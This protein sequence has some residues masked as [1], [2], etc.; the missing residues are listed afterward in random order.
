MVQPTPPSPDARITMARCRPFSSLPPSV[1]DAI[2]ELV[3]ECTFDA[4]TSLIVEGDVGD[5]LYVLIE[6]RARVSVTGSDGQERT[7]DRLDAPVVVGEMALVMREPRSANVVA[8]KPVRALSLAADD[9]ERMAR[10]HP[11]LAVLLT[12]IVA[13]RLG[14]SALDGLGGK[15]VGGYRIVCGV[16]KGGMAVV[17]KAAGPGS[18][19]PVALKMMSHRLI[20]QPGALA[21][22]EREAEIVSKQRHENVIRLLDRFAAYNTRFLVMEFCDGLSL[23][24]MVRDRGGLT[25]KQVRPII[26]QLARALLYVHG[27][28]V[29]HRDLKPSNVLVTRDGIVKLA[30][31]GLARPDLSLEDRSMTRS[32]MFIGTPK[33][34]APEQF[35]GEDPDEKSDFYSLACL[36]YELLAGKALFTPVNLAE[37]IHQK[38]SFRMPPAEEIGH[39]ISAEMFGVLDGGL[40]PRRDERRLDLL[41]LSRWAGPVDPALITPVEG[42][43][44]D[45]AATL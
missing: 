40:R 20:Y 4:G 6:G 30:D 26:G 19:E 24:E 37:A 42:R 28:S 5:A 2:F 1:S 17:Y 44:D 39:G 36:C 33:Y 34:M 23:D 13:D 9:F 15:V 27:Q 31:F 43:G 29:I 45:D 22:F 25:E 8:E 11:Q 21:R 16:G 10:K 18:D 14:A 35:A 7:I 38:A 3:R 41:K 32:Q 12:E